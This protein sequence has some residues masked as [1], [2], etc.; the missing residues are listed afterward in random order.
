MLGCRARIIEAN[1]RLVVFAVRRYSAFFG[2]SQTLDLIQDGNLGLMRAVDKFDH[3]RGYRFSTYA[4]WWIRQGITRAVSDKSRTIRI[5][6]RTVENICQVNRARR[7]LRGLHGREPSREELVSETGLPLEKVHQALDHVPEP[8]SLDRP[9]GDGERRDLG[10]LIPDSDTPSPAESAAD[11]QRE[12]RVQQVLSILPPREERIIRQRF[13]IGGT[14]PRT[15][16]AVGRDMNLTRERVR[17]LEA[18]ALTRLRNRCP[19]LRELL[20]L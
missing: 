3:R 18:R 10:S 5:P 11:H 17:Q 20:D 13:G 19:D 7:V 12:A 6:V 1:L 15:L 16:E 8:L 2:R 9:L 14:V 4:M